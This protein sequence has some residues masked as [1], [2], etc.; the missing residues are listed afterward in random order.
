V[1][2]EDSGCGV[3]LPSASEALETSPQDPQGVKGGAP[4]VNE[5]VHS[6][7]IED[8]DEEEEDDS[9]RRAK[10]EA[11]RRT[12]GQGDQEG[13][14]ALGSDSTEKNLNDVQQQTGQPFGSTGSIFTSD[15]QESNAILTQKETDG[16]TET[17]GNPNIVQSALTT[18]NGGNTQ[19]ARI[20]GGNPPPPSEDDVDSR[21]QDGEDTTSEGKINA[22]S[23]ETADTPQSHRPKGT[24]GTGKDTKAT[25][26]TANSTDKTNTQNSD[27]STAVSH[28]TSPLLL[29]LVVA[30]AAAAAVV[31][32]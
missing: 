9:G 26:V 23:P 13:T 30:C 4:G 6:T 25:T 12:E 31:T 20:A 17:D 27:S 21:K 3:Q 16:K 1:E 24:E 32:A 14:V 19:P 28:T 7:T 29:L 11:E 18:D 22:P 5:N 2:A 10:V 8:E 15:S